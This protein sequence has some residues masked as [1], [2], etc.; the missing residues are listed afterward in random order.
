MDSESGFQMSRGR[1]NNP[2]LKLTAAQVVERY[3][4][5]LGRA[6]GA[7]VNI[8]RSQYQAQ[9][10]EAAAID[11]AGAMLHDPD[12][13]WTG[14]LEAARFIVETARGKARFWAH[15]GMTI[16]PNAMLPDGTT[17]DD[18]VAAA[19][20]LAAIGL[21]LDDLV[22]RR[23]PTAQWPVRVIEAI[24]AEQVALYDEN[25]PVG[26]GLDEKGDSEG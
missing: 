3:Q 8:N 16:D 5:K 11:R 6:G 18:G 7:F 15:D 25:P 2:Q 23:V 21:E 1:Q 20:R 22:R 14:Q 26:D 13:P 9:K 24:P 17:V 12:V 4:H 10:W 19:N